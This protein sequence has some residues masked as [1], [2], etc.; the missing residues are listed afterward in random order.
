MA[1]T[2]TKLAIAQIASG[3]QSIGQARAALG[4]VT[5]VLSEGYAQLD[6]LTSIADVRNTA[7]S[8]LDSNNAYAARIYSTWTDEAD[9]LDQEISIL[10]STQVATCLEQAR[11][12]VRLIED[13][14]NEDIWNFVQLL[15]S[16]LASAVGIAQSAGNAVASVIKV[17][18]AF[19]AALLQGLWPIVLLVGFGVVLFF[20]ARKRA[21]KAL[22]S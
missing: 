4:V 8:L 1:A 11:S 13:I 10:K 20:W 17:P 22:V 6:R 19:G 16:A 9:L 7:R 21:L 15:Q 12:N 18:L 3:V 5:Q 2:D 14:A